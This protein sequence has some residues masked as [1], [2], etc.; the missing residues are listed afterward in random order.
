[1]ELLLELIKKLAQEFTSKIIYFIIDQYKE[2]IDK[3]NVIIGEIKNFVNKAK[4]ISAIICNSLNENDFRN[5]LQLYL[6]NKDN[7]FMDYLFINKLATG[8]EKIL[9]N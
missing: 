1:M 7:F 9:K 2:K 3:N 5:A 8:P 4:N 6:K